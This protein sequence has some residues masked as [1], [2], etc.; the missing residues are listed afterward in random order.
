MKTLGDLLRTI[1]HKKLLQPDSKKTKQRTFLTGGVRRW[2]SVLNLI[3]K[4]FPPPVRIPGQHTTTDP[5]R[6][7]DGEL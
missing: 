7:Q 3:A 5:D 1:K 6:K 4:I 2:R